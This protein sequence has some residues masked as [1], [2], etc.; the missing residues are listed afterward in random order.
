MAAEK[1]RET[2]LSKAAI[3]IFLYYYTFHIIVF[4]VSIWQKY[5]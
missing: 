2:N 3:L 1:I 5:R 4:G